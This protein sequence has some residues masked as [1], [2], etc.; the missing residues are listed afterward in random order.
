[1]SLYYSKVNFKKEVRN[2]YYE[3]IDWSNLS[4]FVGYL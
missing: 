3:F 4:L 2:F 1:V